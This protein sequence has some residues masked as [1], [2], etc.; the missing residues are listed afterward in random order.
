MPNVAKI[1]DPAEKNV[2]ESKVQDPDLEG[3]DVK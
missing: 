3:P 1:K 2:E